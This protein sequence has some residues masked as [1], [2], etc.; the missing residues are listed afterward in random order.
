MSRIMVPA[1][2]FLTFISAIASAA[3]WYVDDSVAESG[4]GL[5]WPTAFKK[6][7]EAINAASQGDTVVV[8]EG[9]Y[10]ERVFIWDKNI[11]LTSTD[12]LDPA[13]VENTII[14]GNQWGSVVRFYGAIDERCVLSGFTIT[15]GADWG[16]GVAGNATPPTIRNN[17]ITRNTAVG[18]E[19]ACGGGLFEC[20]GL[21]ENNV[22]SDNVA[23]G[24]FGAGFGGALS[25]CAGTIRNN[26]I[27]GNKAIGW[28]FYPY[29]N[30]DPGIGGGLWSCD[31]TVENNLIADNICEIGGGGA[32]YC[33]ALFRGNTI[34]GNVGGGLYACGGPI[35]D[36]LI[37]NNSGSGLG[38]CGGPIENNIIYGN[39]SRGISG[40][41]Y[42][43]IRNNLVY[44]NLGGGVTGLYH[45]LLENCVIWANG[46]DGQLYHYGA[47]P[48]YS[49]IQ[50]WTGG[51]EGNI[52][53]EPRFVDAEKGDFRLMPDSPCIDAGFNDPELPE[54]DIAGMHRVMFGGKS[55]T[56]DMGAYEFYINALT[57][58]PTPD[59]TTFTWSS[60]S[61]KT[62]SIF[63]SS[64]LLT[65]HL[66]VEA[67]PS[68]GNTTT[69]WTDDGSK[70]G[71]PPSLVPRRFYRILE[72]P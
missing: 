48:R 5:T 65:W 68:S 2:W 36:N 58:G 50:D 55:L 70:T 57:R 60:L 66:G 24:E 20:H 18:S 44:A 54:T 49:C 59:Q 28:T 37:F 30:P 19:I 33:D 61:Q 25:Q 51:G 72:N 12:P 22:I 41:D 9:T 45:T 23:G 53:E 64:D 10:L 17:V 42:A 35:L 71:L 6:I 1:I 26:T 39:S 34:T 13:V 62:Y 29:A 16:G 7:K 43:V 27:V 63:Y 32:A 11:V 3:T 46:G 38:D 52:S 31:G 56:V 69:S 4:D 14:D 67:F 47:Q 8:A 15:N 40:G 21:I